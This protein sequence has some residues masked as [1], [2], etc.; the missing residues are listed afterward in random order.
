MGVLQEAQKGKDYVDGTGDFS[1]NPHPDTLVI[2]TADHECSGAVIIGASTKTDNALQTNVSSLGNSTD[3][4]PATLGQPS[5]RN[6]VVGTY[7]AA[8]FPKYT[9]ATDGYPTVWDPA[10]KLLVGYGANGDRYENFRTRPFPSRP[11]IRSNR[12]T[13]LPIRGITSPTAAPPVRVLI[14]RLMDIS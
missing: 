10:Y 3:T 14:S 12:V 9:I 7:A 5:L 1:G 2:V 11:L 4:A 6:A 8:G 13:A